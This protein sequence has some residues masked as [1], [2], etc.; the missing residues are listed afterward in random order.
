M[1][2]SNPDPYVF[3]KSF[4]EAHDEPVVMLQSSGSTGPPKLITITHGSLSTLDYHHS[5]PEV[6]ERKKRDWAIWTFEGEARVYTVFPFFH[7]AGF[8]LSVH[9]T[10]FNNTSIVLGPPNVIPDGILLKNIMLQQKLRAMFLPPSVVE[11]MLVDPGAIQF[12]KDL[13]FL[14]YSG[15]PFNPKTGDELSKVVE[16]V[17]PYGATETFVIPKLAVEREDWVWHEF[18]PFSKHEMRPFD[19]TEGTYEMVVYGDESAKHI[20]AIYHNLPGVTEYP[21]KDLFTQHPTKPRLFKYYGRR[22]D[23]IVLAN[24][25][26]FNPIPLELSVQKHPSLKGVLVV[27]DGRIQ[28]AIIVEPKEPLDEKA[29]AKL[30]HDIWLDIEAS[31]TLAAGPGRIHKGMVICASPDKP[32]TRTI[33]GTIVRKQTSETYLSD[34]ERLYLDC[35]TDGGVTGPEPILKPVFRRQAIVDFVRSILAISFADGATIGA[36]EDFYAHG[37]DS[38][39]TLSIASNLRRLVGAQSSAPVNWI[40]ARTISRIQP[41]LNSQTETGA[42]ARFLPFEEFHGCFGR[43]DRIRGH[44]YNDTAFKEPRCF[45][46]LLPQQRGRLRRKA[47]SIHDSVAQFLHKATYLKAE[48]GQQFFGL[49]KDKYDLLANEVDAIV[50]N[51]WRLDFGLAIRSFSP[52]L[53]ATRDLVNLSVNSKKGMRITFVS[54]VSSV[55]AM[56]QRTTVPEAPV[57]DPLASMNTAYAQSKLAAERILSTATE[58]LGIPVNIVRV[59]QV[60]GPTD[61]CQWPEQ[62]WISALLRTSKTLGYIPEQVAAVDWTPV[63]ILSFMMH[64]IILQPAQAEDQNQIRFYNISHPKPAPWGLLI[65]VAGDLLDVHSTIPLGKWTKK[66]K[67]IANP[68]AEDIEKMPALRLL[69]YYEMMGDGM[70]NM[71]LQTDNA[72][73]NFE[74]E[75]PAVDE[76]MLG[77]WLRSWKL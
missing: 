51:S 10:V 31:N 61:G 15:A 11:E 3:S 16:L 68:T 77:N 40:S 5:L 18:S 37:L 63:D 8:L 9:A 7:L 62:P 56:A 19:P 42:T 66:L 49:T 48:L 38:I 53:R 41:S 54:S 28:T 59:P 26:K 32:F 33:K 17:S 20:S 22:D 69:G 36:A 76:A 60:G 13:D 14:A 67:D 58:R 43:L 73:R 64:D 65:K 4:E 34:I 25:E 23:I 52:F 50:Y 1:T 75:V 6:P 27:G 39:Q 44:V 30:L 21:T 45:A 74:G 71:S 47:D 55:S 35:P 29:R 70:E 12:F 24:G 2:K 57:Q 72:M 46:D